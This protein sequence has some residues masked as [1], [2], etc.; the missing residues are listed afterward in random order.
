MPILGEIRMFAGTFAP[1][2]WMLCAGQPLPISQYEA[3]YTLLG[4][5]YGGDGTATFAL[6]DLRGR[7][8][9]HVGQ[10][11]GLSNYVLGQKA[12]AESVTLLVNQIA[13]H[14]HPFQAQANKDSSKTVRLNGANAYPG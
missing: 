1:V 13:G 10:G 3:L 11:Q 14:N 4:T 2:G 8:P 7:G 5:T 9:V 12:G 6:P